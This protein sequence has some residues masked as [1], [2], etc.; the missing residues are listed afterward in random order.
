[1]P[2]NISNTLKLH[3]HGDTPGRLREVRNALAGTFTPLEFN[4]LIPQPIGLADPDPNVLSEA[5]S[6]WNCANWGTKWGA[7]DAVVD[8]DESW[9]FSVHFQTAWRWPEPIIRAILDRFPDIDV[10]F[11]SGGE[12]PS[13]A[14]YIS[15]D[16]ES[17]LVERIWTNENDPDFAVREMMFEAMNRDY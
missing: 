12:G 15:R 1:M 11:V 16:Q 14:V 2:N 7:Y 8:Q 17:G 9:V 10:T 13:V 4:Q 3:Y 5:E 6:N